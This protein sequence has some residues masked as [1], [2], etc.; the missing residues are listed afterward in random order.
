LASLGIRDYDPRVKTWVGPASGGSW[1]TAANWSPS[2]VPGAGDQV[3][4]AGKSVTLAAGA[5]VAGLDLTGGATLSVA[6]NGNRVLRTSNLNIDGTSKLNLNDNDLI[7]DYSGDISASPIGSRNGA[8][9]TGVTGMIARG[10]TYGDWSGTGLVTTTQQ[11]RTGVTTLAVAEAARLFD[12]SGNATAMFAG[13]TVDGTAVL[14]KYTY[15][16]DLNLDGTLDGADYGII[17]N[18]V[19]LPGTN[20]YENGDFNFDGVIDGAD[21]GLIDNAIQLQGV[22]L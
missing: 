14:V 17:D 11:A 21:Y 4:I 8:G 16:G 3:T 2:G 10:Y 5:T 7:I 20:R 1:S 6:A 12:L 15:T 9:Y 19:Q 22:P 13:Q 18:Y